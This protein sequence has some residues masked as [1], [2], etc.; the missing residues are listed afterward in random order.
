[1]S[2]LDDT[3]DGVR[4]WRPAAAPPGIVVAFSGRGVAPAGEAT[5]TAFLARRLAGA[6]GLGATPIHWATQ[7]HGTASATIEA[8]APGG[9]AENVG[10]CDALATALT[11]TAVVVQSADCVPILLAAS[12]AVGAAHAG[13]RGSAKNVAASA[14]A[15]LGRLGA[16]AATL[17]AWIGPSIGAC[18]YEVGGEVAA[19][20][21]GDF[22][23]AGCGGGYRLD[24]RAVNAAQLVE[25][26]VAR[27]AISVHPG[28]TRC[29]GEAYASYRR[30]GA[31]AGRMIALIART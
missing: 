8:R 18:C 25:A 9:R 7:V 6:L 26:G 13:W 12:A 16:R 29:G 10:E 5:P 23:R 24:L 11:G 31:K 22:V 15:A 21:A 19:Q 4:I 2:W 14:V 28:C 1:M 30:D 3:L 17:R 20:F 27:E